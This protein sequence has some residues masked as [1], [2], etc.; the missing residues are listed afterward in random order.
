MWHAT[1]RR[2]TEVSFPAESEETVDDE[3]DVTPDPSDVTPDPNEETPEPNEGTPEPRD[4][5]AA[6]QSA[7]VSVPPQNTDDDSFS[8]AAT[9]LEA[10][11]P[12]NQYLLDVSLTNSSGEDVTIASEAL[13]LVGTDGTVYT[14][15]PLPPNIRPAAVDTT[16]EDNTNLRGFAQFE[17]PADA[18][19]SHVRWCLDETCETMIGSVILNLPDGMGT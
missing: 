2:S 1:T 3:D 9:R 13:A 4:D 14:P 12:E 10:L 19:I 15:V 16:L 11:E 18:Q 7:S 8:I 17:L 6:A 5:N